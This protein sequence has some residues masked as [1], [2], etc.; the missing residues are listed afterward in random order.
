M[1]NDL[2][3]TILGTGAERCGRDGYGEKGADLVL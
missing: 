3:L 2:S 1:M